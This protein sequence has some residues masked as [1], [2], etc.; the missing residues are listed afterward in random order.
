MDVNLNNSDSSEK[1]T[2]KKIEI[3]AGDGKDLD[4][5]KVY[6]HINIESPEDEVKKKEKIVI[7]ESKK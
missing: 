6:N 4:I 1:N 3:V 5:S 7:P 2:D